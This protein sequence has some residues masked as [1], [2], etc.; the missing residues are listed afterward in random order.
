MSARPRIALRVHG[1]LSARDCAAHARA[2]EDAGFSTVW[3]AENAFGRGAMSG[4]AASA[5]ATR[6]IRLGVGVF[7]P[8]TRHP[9]LIAMETAALDEL[10]DGRV[11]LGIGSGIRHGQMGLG[12]PRRIAAVRDAIQIVSRLLRGETVEY[13]GP[14]F[15]AH[16]ARLECPLRRAAVPIFMA[17]MGDRALDLGGRLAD[18]VMI[19]NLSP[20][21]FT[22]RAVGL[23]AR[24]A[25]A[26]ERPM[27][28]E[29]VQYVTGAIDDDPR[30]A[31]RRAKAAVGPMLV[32]YCHHGRASAATQS[33]L[34]DYNGLIPDEFARIVRR[35]ADGDAPA[36]VI[37]DALLDC[38]AIA[39][40]ASECLDR[41]DTYG[42]AGVTELGFSF[43]GEQPLRDIARVGRALDSAPR[44]R[45]DER[46][47]PLPKG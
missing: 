23:V 33:A 19:S 16:G 41:C 10:S 44:A 29:I 37:D 39:G 22:R 27:P 43:A 45:D 2:A 5:L 36:D 35:L 38:Y 42:E 21:A 20:P 26:A 25:A 9:T 8:F 34:R 32:A 11:V 18:G 6:T 47:S 15:S 31:R 30:A 7:N 17:A 14:V 1:G 3:F 40:T 12:A 4:L 46:S 13:E 28:G 24:G